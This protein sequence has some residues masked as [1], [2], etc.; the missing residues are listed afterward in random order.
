V[1][2]QAVLGNSM[3]QMCVFHVVWQNKHEDTKWSSV[4]ST[5]GQRQPF[6]WSQMD[7]KGNLFTED[8]T[9]T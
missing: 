4:V 9:A 6:V 5:N 7:V 3:M 1:A 2:D 8:G